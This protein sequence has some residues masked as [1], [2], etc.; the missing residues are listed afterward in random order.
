MF[1][2]KI[3]NKGKMPTLTTSTQHQTGSPKNGERQEKEIN[4]IQ[5]GKK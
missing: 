3:R 4:G 1:P 2:T 5:N